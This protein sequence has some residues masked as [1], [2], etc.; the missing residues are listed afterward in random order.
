MKYAHLLSAVRPG[1]QN[2]NLLALTAFL[3]QQDI[4]LV[5]SGDNII[6]TCDEQ[7]TDPT[8]TAEI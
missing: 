1:S 8:F 2:T 7:C 6:I 4:D 5:D 3:H